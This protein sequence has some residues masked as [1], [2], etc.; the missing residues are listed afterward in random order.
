MIFVR[1]VPQKLDEDDFCE[2]CAQK[3]DEDDFC[4]TSD[5]KIK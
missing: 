5:S 3:L 4:E 2:K 1:H